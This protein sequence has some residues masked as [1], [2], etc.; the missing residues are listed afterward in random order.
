M[1][2]EGQGGDLEKDLGTV[3]KTK[4]D[5]LLLF[6]LQGIKKDSGQDLK[7]ILSTSY[8]ISLNAVAPTSRRHQ[9]LRDGRS[10]DVGV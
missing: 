3:W 10:D 4:D 2:L 5:R 1:M 6:L 9:V 7:R 8:F